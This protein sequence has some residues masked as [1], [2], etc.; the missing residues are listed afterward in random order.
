ML[1][2][3]NGP[4]E[5]SVVRSFDEVTEEVEEGGE[6]FYDGET[7][8]VDIIDDHGESVDL[9]FRDG[10]MAFNVMKNWYTIEDCPF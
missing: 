1:I 4:A 7:V 6:A 5:L 9:Q 3:W 8:Q 2:S 10:S